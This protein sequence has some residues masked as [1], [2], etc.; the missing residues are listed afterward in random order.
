[1][2]FTLFTAFGRP[3]IG[4]VVAAML[5]LPI[6]AGAWAGYFR[7]ESKGNRF[8]AELANF[9]IARERLQAKAEH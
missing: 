3:G 1:M 2:L 8:L 7:L 5:F 4:A 6:A 9:E